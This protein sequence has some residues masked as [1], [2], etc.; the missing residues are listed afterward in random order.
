[1]KKLLLGFSIMFLAMASM[2]SCTPDDVCED[3]YWQKVDNS[4]G[5]VVDQGTPTEYCGAALDI[6]K[7]D[8]PVVVG[9]Y[10]T[11]WVCN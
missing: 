1:M 8:Q 2:T 11:T 3:C 10:T 9:N 5:N 7:Q 4:N 6:I